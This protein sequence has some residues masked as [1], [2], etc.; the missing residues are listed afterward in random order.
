MPAPQQGL[1]ASYF[2]EPNGSWRGPQ[3]GVH[4]CTS[5]SESFALRGRD[6][7]RFRSARCYSLRRWTLVTRVHGTSF[8]WGCTYD[9]CG[10]YSFMGM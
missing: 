2:M 5:V 8:M 1:L 3:K 6:E 4:L 7:E 10:H 9:S